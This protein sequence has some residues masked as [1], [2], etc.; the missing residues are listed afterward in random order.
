MRIR[1]DLR[2]SMVMRFVD[3]A[4]REK[5]GVIDTE[6]ELAMRRT[7]LVVDQEISDTF[8]LGEECLRHCETRMLRIVDGRVTKLGLRVRV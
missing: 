6:T 5:I 4:V 2:A 8:D 1:I 7:V 3:D